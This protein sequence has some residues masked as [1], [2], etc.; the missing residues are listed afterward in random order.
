L[1][2]GDV[3]AALP[4]PHRPGRFELTLEDGTVQQGVATPHELG[5][6]LPAIGLPG[7]HL[8]ELDGHQTTLAIAP[9]AC[10][11][12]NEAV[13]EHRPWGLAVQLYS[14]RRAGDGGIGDYEA[15]R[16]FVQ[17]AAAHG[18]DAVAISPTHA[19]FSADPDRFSPYAPSS[20]IA[21]NVLHAAVPPFLGSAAFENN[22]LV[23]WPAAS[24]ARLIALRQVFESARGTPIE[25]EFAAFRQKSGDVL[26][27]HARFEALHAERFLRHGQWNWRDWPSE[28]RDPHSPAVAAFTNSHADEVAFHAFLQFLA[29]CGLADAQ[30]AARAAGM[31]IGLISDLAVGTDGG[32]SHAWSR[33]EEM[34]LGVSIGAPP[35][36]LG[37]HG[38]DWG[39]AAFS[40]L[41]LARRGF[42]A[43][44]EMLR[45]ALRH[46]GGVRIDHVMGLARLW[47]VPEGASAKDG[48]YL[49]FPQDDLLR[50]VALESWRHRAVVLG[51]D[52]GTVP[53][54]FRER[55]IARRLLGLR[56]LWFERGA[57]YF[58]VPD[59]WSRSAVGVTSTHDLPTVAGWWR[60]R[61]L[62]WRKQLDLFADANAAW[63]EYENR[64]ADRP[65]L[66][67]AM[68]ASGAAAGDPP[69]PD[70]PTRVVDAAAAHVAASACEMVILPIEDALGLEEQPN[71]PGTID[72][73]PN[74]R[75]RLAAPVD[76]VLEAPDVAA[77]LRRLKS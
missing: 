67:Q 14:L 28:L 24:R 25:Q 52:L 44:I 43:F 49:H 61:D 31:S 74:W 48:A 57:E 75:R 10:F 23:D 73:H 40:P 35:D 71:L 12:V 70:E 21:F 4:V 8:L 47:V 20:R 77:R 30:A 41:G 65:R 45:A 11:S 13:P 33:Q 26:E 72:Q 17:R 51:E 29:E 64:A 7:Y 66:W 36:L 76:T 42:A 68:V 2:T 53:E 34:L 5:A 55:L 1:L 54:G 6:L 60:G 19:Q 39:L 62:E 22:S 37:P 27:C 46:A 59:D 32:G 56:V 50:L 15:L 18:A 16:L 3:G 38:Q 63:F 9:A 58:D 69:P